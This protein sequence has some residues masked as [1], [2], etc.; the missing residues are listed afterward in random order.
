MLDSVDSNSSNWFHGN[1]FHSYDNLAYTHDYIHRTTDIVHDIDTHRDGTH[2]NGNGNSSLIQD[3][4]P[5]KVQLR[6]SYKPFQFFNSHNNNNSNTNNTYD[7]QAYTSD[8]GSNS[9]FRPNELDLPFN[10]Y[11]YNNGSSSS[12]TASSNSTSSTKRK[13]EELND[14][15]SFAT[16]VKRYRRSDCNPRVFEVSCDSHND[17]TLH[18]GAFKKYGD[19][20]R[21][22]GVNSYDKEDIMLRTVKTDSLSSTTYFHPVESNDNDTSGYWKLD[23][24]TSDDSIKEGTQ[25]GEDNS[26]ATDTFSSDACTLHSFDTQLDPFDMCCQLCIESEPH[27]QH[28]YGTTTHSNNGT[29]IKNSSDKSVFQSFPTIPSLYEVPSLQQRSHFHNRRHENHEGSIQQQQQQQGDGKTM[30]SKGQEY[31]ALSSRHSDAS[32]SVSSDHV[33]DSSLLNKVPSAGSNDTTTDDDSDTLVLSH[34]HEAY[35]DNEA[36]HD[37]AIELYAQAPMI[38]DPTIFDDKTKEAAVLNKGISFRTGR[39]KEEDRESLR[40]RMNMNLNGL[41][42]VDISRN[43]RRDK[44]RDVECV[45]GECNDEYRFDNLI[46]LQKHMFVDHV[47]GASDYSCNWQDCLFHGDDVGGSSVNHIKDERDVR[48]GKK[49]KDKTHLPMKEKMM[50]MMMLNGKDSVKMDECAYYECKWDECQMIF[51]SKK[52]LNEHIEMNHIP[53]RKSQYQCHW[54]SCYK[55]FSQRQKLLRHIKVHTGYKPYKCDICSKMFANQETLVQHKRIHSGEK[56]YKCKI[57]GKCFG[58][59]SSLKIHI[60]THTGEKPLKCNICDK[61]FNESSNLNKH[62]KTHLKEY[63]CENCGKRFS[64]LKYLRQHESSRSCIKKRVLQ[65]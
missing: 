3:V 2:G 5:K 65:V 37:H 35:V 44:G 22:I 60:R 23:S 63:C 30:D 41:T 50:M 10:N 33:M 43:Q 11:L 28:Y 13:F 58:G 25:Y 40:Y 51:D 20:N 48:F 46:E 53:R 15:A 6:N 14:N 19:P 9:P 56:P 38:N 57:C 7:S 32:S 55:M 26:A 49:V 17:S 29:A 62:L 27:M 1:A 54:S 39:M 61:R 47:P 8:Y 18:S 16:T 21:D 59:S 31:D 34:S 64:T 4:D 24:N 52:S 45:W 36:Y 12:A 42:T